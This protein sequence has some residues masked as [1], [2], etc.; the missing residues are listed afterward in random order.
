MNDLFQRSQPSFMVTIDFGVQ[1]CY[2]FSNRW[3]AELGGVYRTKI[4]TSLA[5]V[6]YTE[7]GCLLT[8]F[9]MG[10]GLFVHGEFEALKMQPYAFTL[11]NEDFQDHACT[12]NF[13]IGKRFNISPK[14]K[15]TILGLYRV[16]VSGEVPGINRLNVRFGF[17]YDHYRKKRKYYRQTIL[18]RM[19]SAFRILSNNSFI[20]DTFS[21]AISGN[22]FGQ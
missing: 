6:V 16:P 8:D 15:G 13:G 1:V 20:M 10:K 9:T 11:L 5:A 4:N 3:T 2:D 18:T 19:T 7:E 14:I 21:I 17:E 12:A 22:T